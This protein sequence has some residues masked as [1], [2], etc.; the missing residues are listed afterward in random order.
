MTLY[1]AY[2]ANLHP[3]VMATR[4][5]ASPLRTTG[6]LTGWRLTFGGGGVT[7]GAL[8]T[9]VEDSASSVFVALYDLSPADEAAI[10]QCD[11]IDVD[12]YRRIRLRVDTL[13]GP[14]VACL[15]VIN[16]YE[17]GLPAPQLLA[18][19]ADAAEAAGAPADYVIELRLRPCS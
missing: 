8:P 7:G 12:L 16:T 9:I 17:G 4:A 11:G 14:V 5:P 6:W 1:A 3:H 2:G 13:E 19:L 10:D 15:S 18:D